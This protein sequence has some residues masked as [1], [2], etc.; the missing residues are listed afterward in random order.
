MT[1]S[2]VAHMLADYY[3]ILGV[4][5]N[6][7]RVA[8]K[9]AYWSIA[10][11]SHPDAN[12]GDRSKEARFVQATE[13]YRT[14]SD[15]EL[16]SQYDELRC[17]CDLREAGRGDVGGA[18]SQPS[19]STTGVVPVSTSGNDAVSEFFWWLRTTAKVVQAVW[20]R[21]R[22]PRWDPGVQRFR[23]KDGRFAAR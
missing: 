10:R 2:I 5:K 9:A 13:A 18:V 3:A 16:R 20:G 23:S 12:R 14:L 6:A 22:R 11:A 7:S 4:P 21:P 17:Q 8:I 15:D 1:T 19:T